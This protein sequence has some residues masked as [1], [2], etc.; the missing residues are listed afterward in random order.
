MHKYS[1]KYQKEL[2]TGLLGLQVDNANMK[3]TKIVKKEK[4]YKLVSI[5]PL[6]TKNNFYAIILCCMMGIIRHECMQSQNCEETF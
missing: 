2:H 5:D 3:N 4:Y 1:N 6:C